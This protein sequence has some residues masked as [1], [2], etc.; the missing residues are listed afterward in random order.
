V[1]RFWEKVEKTEGCW[2]WRG[3]ITSAKYGCFRLNGK[4]RQAH[5]VAHELLV[6]PIP[7]RRGYHGKLMM[8][9]CDNRRCVRPHAEHAQPSTQK[10]N[11]QDAARKGRLGKACRW[12][13]E[14]ILEIRASYE[15]G[16]TQTAIAARY[17]TAQPVISNIVRFKRRK[18][19]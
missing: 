12:S 9:A 15:A 19:A 17:E 1:E 7:K 13:D 11:M 8:H 5:H 16:E 18:A 14:Q 6:G 4:V 3:A 10:Q 2:N